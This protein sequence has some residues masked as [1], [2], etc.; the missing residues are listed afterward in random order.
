MHRF[1]AYDNNRMRMARRFFAFSV[2]SGGFLLSRP[3]DQTL[4]ADSEPPLMPPVDRGNRDVK[5][6]NGKSR[7]NAIARDEHKKAL[8]EAAELVTLSEQLRDEVQKAGEYVVSVAAVRKTEEIEK[9]A[10]KIRGRLKG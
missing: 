4:P 3:Q 6:P 10:R 1:V 9:L 8:A 7:N 5:L 2:L